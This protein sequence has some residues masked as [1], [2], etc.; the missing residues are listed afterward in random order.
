MKNYYSI[1]IFIILV[2]ILPS[3]SHDKINNVVDS[4][5][6]DIDHIGKVNEQEKSIVLSFFEKK[7]KAD[8]LKFGTEYTYSE[9]EVVN[10]TNLPG[11]A[12]VIN[13]KSDLGNSNIQRALI[14]VVSDDAEI[15]TYYEYEKKAQV[16]LIL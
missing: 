14:L 11:K 13:Y 8:N 9:P 12:I 3:C 6:Q 4:N 15:L 2:G 5:G 10:Y 1:I 16:I 7:E